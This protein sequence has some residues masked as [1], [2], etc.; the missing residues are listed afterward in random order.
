MFNYVY[1][2][3]DKNIPEDLIMEIMHNAIVTN[4]QMA[5]YVNDKIG[6]LTSESYYACFYSSNKELVELL[7]SKNIKKVPINDIKDIYFL[8][9]LR[10]KGFEYHPDFLSIDLDFEVFKYAYEDGAILSDETVNCLKKN[11]NLPRVCLHESKKYYHKYVCNHYQCS[12]PSFK[13]CI[14][15]SRDKMRK[16]LGIII[17]DDFDLNIE[18]S[19]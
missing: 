3:V 9:Y 17:T 7:L 10:E 16:Y 18:F 4:T 6:G 14:Y 12:R 11:D 13:H 1:E 8:I 2:R 5:L 19:D 15:D